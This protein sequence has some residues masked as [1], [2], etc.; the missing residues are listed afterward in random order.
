MLTGPHSHCYAPATLKVK[1][2]V[3]QAQG[4]TPHIVPLELCPRCNDAAAA[5]GMLTP[6]P[7]L[8][9]PPLLLLL[10]LLLLQ[11]HVPRAFFSFRR[12]YGWLESHPP[13]TAHGCCLD[14]LEGCPRP[15]E[16]MQGSGSHPPKVQGTSYST[17]AQ[18]VAVRN[19]SAA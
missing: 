19:S 12:L 8:P 4:R 6:P 13:N 1:W 11:A 5:C 9:P 2:P 7:P 15:A 3:A 14:M 18:R 16:L 10:L 17:A